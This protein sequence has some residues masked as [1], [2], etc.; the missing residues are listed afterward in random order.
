MRR[1]APRTPLVL[2][3]AVLLLA[4][5]MPAQQVPD[6]SFA[7]ALGAPTWPAGTGPA[8]CV[9]EGHAN[10]HTLAERFA[11]FGRLLA[12]DGWRPVPIAEP[13]RATTLARCRVLVIANAAPA[14]GGAPLAAEE[15]AAI[16]AWVREGGALLLIADHMPFAG[17][18]MPLAASFGVR[19]HDGFAVAPFRRP[20]E[21]DR[22]LATPTIFRKRDGTLADHAVTAGI[23][24]VRT[25]V[26]QA[27]PLPRGAI[28]VLRLPSGT[29]QLYPDTPWEFGPATRRADAGGWSQGAL[30]PY[31]LGRVAVFGEA[32]MFTAQLAGPGGEPAGFNAPG[33]EANARLILRVLRWAARVR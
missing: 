27:F 22:A 10:F 25:F 29:A 12:R 14:A 5:P 21:L 9:D 2:V 6:T 26:G 28:P 13:L 1:A 8:V 7:P 31:G 20:G 32:A 18:A 3:A 33:A 11:P 19:F 23:D 30:L 4:R 24:S 15:I 16:N 17:A